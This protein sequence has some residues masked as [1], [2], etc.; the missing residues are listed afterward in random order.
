MGQ[1]KKSV[2]KALHAD[3]SGDLAAAASAGLQAAMA[4]QAEKLHINFSNDAIIPSPLNPRRQSLDQAGVTREAVAQLAIKDGEDLK[5]W[6]ERCDAY[7]K[8]LD[9]TSRVVWFKLADLA[10]SIL[11][12]GILQPIIVND[13]HIIVA[14]ERRWT[15]SQLA[16][17]Q[18]SRVIVR[19]L[20][21]KQEAV[22]RLIENL[23]RTD[24]SVAETVSGF[25]AVVSMALGVCEPTNDNIT[26]TAIS[27][28]TGAGRTNAAYYRAFCRLPEGDPVLDAILGG[29]YTSVA[30]AYTVAASRVRDIQEGKDQ[31]PVDLVDGA[32]VELPKAKRE[33]ANDKPV[34]ARIKVQLR[35]T[36]NKVFDF[37]AAVEGVPQPVL[38]EFSELSQQWPNA[39]DKQRTLM[40]GRAVELMFEIAESK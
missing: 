37:L 21:D 19:T 5:S 22:F 40:I 24:L 23:Q 15:A 6:Q 12:Q 1:E 36:A 25:R 18:T 32:Q 7:I 2:R 20:T 39:D 29:E 16:G 28:L 27:A 26:M 8:G 3:T 33:P 31:A 34:T 30:A 4:N 11:S 13:K 9:E 10:E 17:K 14:G 35:P 38:A